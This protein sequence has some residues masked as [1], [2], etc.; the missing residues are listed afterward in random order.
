MKIQ[1]QWVEVR[2]LWNIKV[3]HPERSEYTVLLLNVRHLYSLL[4]LSQF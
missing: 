2:S 4:L 1:T 3:S